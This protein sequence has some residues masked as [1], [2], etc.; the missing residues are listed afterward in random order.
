MNQLELIRSRL[1]YA[2]NLINNGEYIRDATE[3]LRKARV[4]L[5]AVMKVLGLPVVPLTNPNQLPLG[6]VSSG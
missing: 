1:V 3:A 4:E 2:D 6:L 5:E